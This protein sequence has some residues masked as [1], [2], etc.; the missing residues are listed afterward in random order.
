MRHFIISA[1]LSISIASSALTLR[2][3]RLDHLSVCWSVGRTQSIFWQNGWLDPGA[4]WDGEWG[5]SR[6]RCIGW[7]WRLSKGKGQFRQQKQL[8]KE[9][10]ICPGGSRSAMRAMP[11]KSVGRGSVVLATTITLTHP[12]WHEWRFWGVHFLLDSRVKNWQYFRRHNIL[13]ETSVYWLSENIDSF[14]IK[15]GVYEKFAKM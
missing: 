11:W 9:G 15:V 2:N 7:G 10:T 1:S 6:D 4:V 14:E 5:R 8:A 12:D 3:I 13:L